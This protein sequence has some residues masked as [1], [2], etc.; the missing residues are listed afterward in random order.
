MILLWLAFAVM[1]IPALWL[2][3]LPLRRAA[4][5]RRAQADFEQR[6]STAELNVAVHRRRLASLEAARERGEIDQARFEDDRLELERSLLDDTAE[7]QRQ[8]LKAASS[9]KLMVPAMMI[10]LVVAAIGWYQL[11]GA[12]GDL[13]LYQAQREV[14]DAPDGNVDTLIARLEKEASRQPD[15]VNV[16][17]S[18]YPLYRDS[19]RINEAR[20]ALE[21]LIELEGRKTWLLAELAEFRY[22]TEGREIS[23]DVKALV[24]EVLASEPAQPKV[25]GM[26]GIEAF[27][28]GDYEQAI[29]HWRRA[30]A[31]M[32]NPGAADSLRQGI[33][34]AQQRLGIEP[35]R[36]DAAGTG[37]GVTVQLSLD[38]SLSERLPASTSVFVVARDTAGE[39]PPLAIQ[40][41]TLGELPLTLTL[42]DSHAMAPGARLSQVDQAHLVVRVSESGQATPQPGDLMGRLEDVTVGSDEPLSLVIDRV[43]E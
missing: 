9:G 39:L 27:E 5:L 26:L 35:D 43:V 28:S 3:I 18:L 40:R 17:R 10:G 11:E 4:S 25:L 37:P 22:F 31:G 12:S 38:P 21:Q 7:L 33:Q 13:A 42:D 20:A 19:G 29:E 8:P 14:L 2:M 15:N 1:L 36:G 32:D 24:D 16:W 41:T 23:G 30:I 34:V 6:D